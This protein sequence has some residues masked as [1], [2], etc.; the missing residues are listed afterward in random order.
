MGSIRKAV[1]DR[2]KRE[3]RPDPAMQAAIEEA[4]RQNK[5]RLRRGITLEP[6]RFRSTTTWKVVA[7]AEDVPLVEGFVRSLEGRPSDADWTKL[8]FALDRATEQ[9][10]PSIRRG[11]AFK[12]LSEEKAQLAA[13][14]DRLLRQGLTLTAAFDQLARSPEYRERFGRRVRAPAARTLHDRW[15]RIHPPQAKT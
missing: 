2:V 12:W 13:D 5:Q 11:G 7:M 4:R 8:K 1:R 10:R 6:L 15:K 3:R 9:R 14:V